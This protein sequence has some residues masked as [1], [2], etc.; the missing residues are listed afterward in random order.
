MNS[1]TYLHILKLTFNLYYFR[2][3]LKLA[4]KFIKGVIFVI[5]EDYLDEQD[6]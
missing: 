5:C 6:V 2:F 4:S 1:K 3:H